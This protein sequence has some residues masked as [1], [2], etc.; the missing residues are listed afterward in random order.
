MVV[1]RCICHETSFREL[2]EIARERGLN[3][4]EELREAG[5]S[6]TNCKLCV[7]YIKRM[8]ET[9]ETHFDLLKPEKRS[10]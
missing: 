8:L 10:V 6:S 9:G 4:V 3:S 5:L 7:P 1:D 2:K